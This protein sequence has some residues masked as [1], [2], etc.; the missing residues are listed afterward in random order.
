MADA[1]Y[2][3]AMNKYFSLK[4]DYES[5]YNA[6]KNK[7]LKNATLSMADKRRKL[8]QIKRKCIHCGKSGGTIFSN[9][10]GILSAV[11]GNVSS[12]CKLDIKIV[13][14]QVVPSYEILSKFGDS[15]QKVKQEI[16]EG[17]F[18]MLFNYIDDTS[19]LKEFR[20]LKKSLE[21]QSIIYDKALDVY[22]TAMGTHAEAEELKVKELDRYL[23]I[24]TIREQLQEYTKTG[25]QSHVQRAVEIYAGP[26]RVILDDIR[27]LKYSYVGM[28]HDDETA[29]SNLIEDRFTPSDME[30]VVKS[31]KKM[32]APVKGRD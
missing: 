10:D 28:T 13:R 17:K 22:A 6:Q 15:I 16:I 27:G 12:P 19:S 5:K 25:E 1:S 18:D 9:T 26:L 32:K 14:E 8:A 4:R 2:L 23:Q 31:G 30:Y 21:G 24:K 20:S 11:C 7:L 29:T 3:E